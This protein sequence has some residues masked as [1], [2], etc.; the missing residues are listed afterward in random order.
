LVA[1][2]SKLLTSL[3]VWE[4]NDMMNVIER[5]NVSTLIHYGYTNVLKVAEQSLDHT[6]SEKPGKDVG[7][8]MVTCDKHNPHPLGCNRYDSFHRIDGDRRFQLTE[9]IKKITD[10]NQRI[11]AFIRHSSLQRIQHVDTLTLPRI[12]VMLE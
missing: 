3:A 6:L 2:F 7:V 12:V 5:D 1:G 11:R 4:R 9:R 8:V 10:D